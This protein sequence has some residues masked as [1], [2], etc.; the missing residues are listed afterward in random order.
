MDEQDRAPFLPLSSQR[1]D[2]LCLLPCPPV[3]VGVPLAL[4]CSAGQPPSSVSQPQVLT[5]SRGQGVP[6]PKWDQ[7]RQAVDS[8]PCS[9]RRAGCSAGS[10]VHR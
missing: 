1:A 8:P 3:E 10:E 9:H 2:C 5:C 7:E 4:F 6:V